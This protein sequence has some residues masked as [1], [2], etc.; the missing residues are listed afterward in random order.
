MTETDDHGMIISQLGQ[1]Y[2]RT[3]DVP[4]I[5]VHHNNKYPW[6][7]APIFAIKHDS[8]YITHYT[9]QFHA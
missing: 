6:S 2:I 4:Q 9:H 7:A 5:T 8:L 1:A 3:N